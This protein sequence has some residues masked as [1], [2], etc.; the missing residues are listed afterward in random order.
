M[1][2]PLVASDASEALRAAGA[3]VNHLVLANES[4]IRRAIPVA[5]AAACK[6][7][8]RIEGVGQFGRYT[9]LRI[10]KA[11]NWLYEQNREWHFTDGTLCVLWCVEFPDA[12]SDY[13]ARSHYIA[14]TRREYNA[15]RHQAPAPKVPCV[16]YT[17]VGRSDAVV[18]I[19]PARQTPSVGLGPAN[20]SLPTTLPPAEHH[21]IRE[22]LSFRSDVKAGE[23]RKRNLEAYFRSNVLNR[24]DFI[25]RHYAD[26]RGSHGGEFFEGQLHHV[27]AHY[28]LRANGRPFRIVVVGQEVGNGPARVSIADRTQA[29]AEGTGRNRRFFSEGAIPARNPHMRGTT[30]LLRL[31]IGRDPDRDYESEWITISGRH[32]VHLFDAFALTN[33][34]LCSAIAA[35]QADTGS[36]RGRSTRTMQQRCGEHFSA[37]IRILEPTVVVNQGRSVRHWMTPL[38]DHERQVSPQLERVRIAGHEFLMASFTHPSVP[39]AGNWG[40]DDR[41]PYLLEVVAPTVRQVHRELGL[42]SGRR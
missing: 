24:H 11:Q 16:E 12:K 34:L 5:A 3:A 40:T 37:T 32:R 26:C 30:S 29:V 9:G 21:L 1:S 27:G 25:C 38:L 42:V 22:S 23:T 35:G 4:A 14:S 41:R 10:A 19:A 2:F 15:G 39:S 20:A 18:R 8:G 28:D 17:H 6:V 31:L 13:A 36:K 33:F 7:K